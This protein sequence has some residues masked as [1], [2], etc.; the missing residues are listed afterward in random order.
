MS[1]YNKYDIIGFAE[2]LGLTLTEVSELYIELINEINSSL[3]ELKTLLINRDLIKI[4]KSIHNIKGVCG[5]YRLSDI[6]EK[7]ST[8]NDLLKSNNYI[9]LE[10]DLFDLFE[11]IYSAE[12]EIRDFFIKQSISFPI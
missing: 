7:S 9:N 11:I 12:K 6:Y 8:I 4:Q 5:N 3:I 2:D 1:Y 10:A